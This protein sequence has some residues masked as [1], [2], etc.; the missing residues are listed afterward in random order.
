MHFLV[1]K[2]KNK[3]NSA[4]SSIVDTVVSVWQQKFDYKVVLLFKSTI[5]A[6]QKLACLPSNVS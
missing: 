1:L 2:L 4:E 3:K 6:V 5:L